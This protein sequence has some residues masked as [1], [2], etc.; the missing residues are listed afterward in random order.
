MPDSS[1]GTGSSMDGAGTSSICII[2][3]FLKMK[4]PRPQSR[5]EVESAF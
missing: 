5:S 3:D 4:T 2:C 1:L